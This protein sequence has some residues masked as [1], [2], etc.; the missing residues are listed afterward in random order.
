MCEWNNIVGSLGRASR[1]NNVSVRTIR[2]P[3]Y[4]ISDIYVY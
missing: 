4:N 1:L 2:R 3:N